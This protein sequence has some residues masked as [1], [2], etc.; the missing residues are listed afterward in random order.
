MDWGAVPAEISHGNNLITLI[1][2]MFMH[3]GWLHIGGNML[4]LWVF[5]DN[6]EDTMGHIKYL[7][8]YLICGLAAGGLQIA[9]QSGQPVPVDRRIG[10]DLRGAGRLPGALPARQDP[11]HSHARHPDHG[12]GSGLGDDRVLDRDPVH[13]RD[14]SLGVQTKETSG[15][16]YF[17]HIGG[18]IAGAALVLLFRDRDIH[19]QQLDAR[20]SNRAFQRTP[21]INR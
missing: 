1:T 4:F 13:Q 3:G 10:R 15:V 14:P 17:A 8:F 21:L 20:A 11:D 5:G 6:I 12:A 16:A 9:D 18:F 7:I 19:Q 2:S